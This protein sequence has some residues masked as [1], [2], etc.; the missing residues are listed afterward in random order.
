MVRR[1]DRTDAGRV[2]MEDFAQVFGLFPE[3]KYA[4]KSYANIASVL[5]AEAAEDDRYEFVRRRLT[6]LSLRCPTFQAIS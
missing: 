1:F 6:I 2:H 3:D 5:W 4:R